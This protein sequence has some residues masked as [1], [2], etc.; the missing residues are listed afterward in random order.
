MELAHASPMELVQS[1]VTALKGERWA[2]IL[3]LVRVEAVQRL[4]DS[5]LRSLVQSEARV[6]R[7]AEDVRAEQ[8]WLPQE[9]A[10]YY[11]EQEELAVTAGLPEQL[12]S[13]G[14]S[15]FRE[16]EVLS[17]ADFF[18]RYLAASSPSAKLRVA[19]ATSPE[20]PRVEVAELLAE[21]ARVRI[22]V[23]GE[24]AESRVQAHVL[25]RQLH[26]PERYDPDAP[27]GHL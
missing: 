1:V 8:P 12:A 4:R 5:T 15:S 27:G 9:V 21:E 17:P 13:W 10:A 14:V 2:D 20:P 24:I 3:P 19:L 26:G 22:V 18:I 7:T 6:P 11:A 25:Y 16:L 23:L